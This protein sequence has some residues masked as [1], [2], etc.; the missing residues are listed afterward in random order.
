MK[1]DSR[2]EIELVRCVENDGNQKLHYKAL[3]KT[4][5]SFFKTSA[6]VWICEGTCQVIAENAPKATFTAKSN[7][8]DGIHQ[9]LAETKPEIFSS[10]IYHQG[11]LHCNRSVKLPF[12]SLAEISIRP[13]HCCT[14]A[15]AL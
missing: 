7:H 14:A 2:Q 13:H 15:V 9:M 10:R 5:L 12:P 11:L 1:V 6:D 8:K 3:H 4:I